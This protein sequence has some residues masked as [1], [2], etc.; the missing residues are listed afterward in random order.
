MTKM[1]M[2][3]V[4]KFCVNKFPGKLMSFGWIVHTRWYFIHTFF[5]FLLVHL[6]FRWFFIQFLPSLLLSDAIHILLEMYWSHSH[7]LHFS[8]EISSCECF[9][10]VYQSVAHDSSLPKA[11]PATP[12]DQSTVKRQRNK[13]QKSGQFF[14]GDARCAHRMSLMRTTSIDHAND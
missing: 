10:C 12:M 11:R 3:K 9:D 13:R 6:F 14:R 1:M 2:E 4:Y 8:T 5:G 7:W